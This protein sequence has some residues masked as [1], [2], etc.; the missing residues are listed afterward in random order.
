MECGRHGAYVVQDGSNR[1]LPD[2]RG[3]SAEDRDLHS[4]LLAAYRQLG[5][6][7]RVLA[8]QTEL[9]AQLLD[10]RGVERRVEAGGLGSVEG[11]DRRGVDRREET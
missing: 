9:I 10:R 1:A 7:E 4:D 6:L 8:D 3:V 2:H 11:I 5:F